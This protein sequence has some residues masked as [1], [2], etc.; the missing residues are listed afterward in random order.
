MT[1][2]AGPAL[3]VLHAEFGDRVAFVTLYVREAHPGERY[4]Q[5]QTFGQKLAHARDYQQRDDIPWPVAVDTIN[6]DYHHALG[7]N[8]DAAYLVDRDGRVA[9][10]S[11]WANDDE[12]LRSAITAL[13]DGRPTP[14]GE[15]AAKVVPLVKSIGTMYETLDLAGVVAKRDMLWAAPPIFGLARMAALF[16]PLPPFGRAAAAIAVSLGG[17]A[18]IG[19]AGWAVFRR[20]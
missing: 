17:L 4:P 7:A 2:S 11:L 13:L 15:R 8:P 12:S 10:R 19:V 20:S 18:V 5:P 9:F 6:G 14:L 3:K 16:G 1:A